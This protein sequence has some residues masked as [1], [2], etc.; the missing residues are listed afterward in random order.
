MSLVDG[1]VK[2][3]GR[4]RA[5]YLLSI[6]FTLIRDGRTLEEMQRGGIGF[7]VSKELM[8]NE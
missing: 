7:K 1:D 6:Q 4:K 2:S 5:F 8:S 3:A